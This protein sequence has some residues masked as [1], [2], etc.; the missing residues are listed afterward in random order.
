MPISYDR[1]KFEGNKSGLVC[2]WKY[3]AVRLDF[4]TDASLRKPFNRIPRR[5]P[6]KCFF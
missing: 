1:T 4:Q 6:V 3:P 2:D 5:K